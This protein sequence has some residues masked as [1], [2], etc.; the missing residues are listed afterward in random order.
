MSSN[1][2]DLLKGVIEKFKPQEKDKKNS[3]ELGEDAP[4]LSPTKENLIFQKDSEKTDPKTK[5]LSEFVLNISKQPDGQKI[6]SLYP[7]KFPP[8]KSPSKR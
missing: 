8:P 7:S 6:S 2:F 5:T 4:L 3:T 1:F